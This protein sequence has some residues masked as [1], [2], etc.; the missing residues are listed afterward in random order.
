MTGIKRL[1]TTIGLA[2]AIVVGA[3]I[4]ASASFSDTTALPTITLSTATV[5]APTDVVGSLKC[6]KTTSTMNVTWTSST[7]SRVSAY[8]VTVHFSD[9]YT[10][11]EDTAATAT[12]WTKDI[13]TYNV[14][15][16]SIRY[17]VT[18]MTDYGWYTES[19]L[20]G[21]FQC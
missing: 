9:G 17:S 13:S 16:Y 5:A 19:A 8:R 21:S 1:L 11:S 12:S 20:T 2:L 4:P 7:S 14:T 15:K 10:Q 18:T 6:A 3:G